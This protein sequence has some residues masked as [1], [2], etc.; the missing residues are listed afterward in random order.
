MFPP[1]PHHHPGDY[2]SPQSTFSNLSTTDHLISSDPASSRHSTYRPVR[3]LPLRYD[4]SSRGSVSSHDGFRTHR[5]RWHSLSQQPSRPL[6][7]GE[8]G[9]EAQG[10]GSSVATSNSSSS[11]KTTASHHLNG[12][13]MLMGLQ[14]RVGH[15]LTEQERSTLAEIRRLSL[16][17]LEGL[18]ADVPFP[19]NLATL[20]SLGLSAMPMLQEYE[21]MGGPFQQQP[22]STL[23]QEIGLTLRGAIDEGVTLADRTFA[24][25]NATFALSDDGEE[26]D[27]QAER[28]EEGSLLQVPG[29]SNS[30]VFYHHREPHQ[31][32]PSH[33]RT[34]QIPCRRGC[35]SDYE[36]A[37]HVS[38]IEDNGGGFRHPSQLDPSGMK[39]FALIEGLEEMGEREMQ[40]WRDRELAL[41]RCHDSNGGLPREV[42]TGSDGWE[43]G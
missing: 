32:I 4:T 38:R 13:D 22:D 27:R 39:D 10:G 31:R 29:S 24:S 17:E 23:P 43:D 15:Q 11:S 35:C 20:A 42:E 25:S 41:A 26:E 6:Q 5:D 9:A 16:L 14:D 18:G 12:S 37:A 19:L 8:S 40:G 28:L 34:H 3:P 1:I 7:I 21:T 36:S 33:P 2:A 30:P